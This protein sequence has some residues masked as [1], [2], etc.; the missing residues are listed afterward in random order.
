M[1]FKPLFGGIFLLFLNNCT[2]N[3]CSYPPQRLGN[4]TG[5][6]DIMFISHDSTAEIVSLCYPQVSNQCLYFRYPDIITHG[7]LLR[8]FNQSV[9]DIQLT[10][11]RTEQIHLSYDIQPDLDCNGSGIAEFKNVRLVSSTL[12]SFNV[13][14]TTITIKKY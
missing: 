6:H 11:G 5:P 3:D 9:I 13:S 14:F 12:D 7:L 8:G 1:L 10:D 2:Y 4:N